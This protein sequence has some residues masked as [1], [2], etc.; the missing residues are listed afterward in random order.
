MEQVVDSKAFLIAAF[1]TGGVYH[2][3]LSPETPWQGKPRD[4][5]HSEIVGRMRGETDIFEDITPVLKAS[6]AFLRS[7]TLALAHIQ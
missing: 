7:T 5:E 3:L 6:Y 1:Q 2:V 4:V